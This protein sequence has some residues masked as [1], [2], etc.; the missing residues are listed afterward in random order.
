MSDRI[1]LPALRNR[2]S[3]RYRV[4]PS[5]CCIQ[6][7]S[8]TQTI[9]WNCKDRRSAAR[10]VLPELWERDRPGHR[11]FEL[12]DE[13]ESKWWVSPRDD[14]SYHVVV[15]TLIDGEWKHPK[16]GRAAGCKGGGAD[17]QA[18]AEGRLMNAM[19]QIAEAHAS[20]LSLRASAGACSPAQGPLKFR[21]IRAAE[22]LDAVVLIAVC[23]IERIG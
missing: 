19:S 20:A 17:L 4:A 7:D 15:H 12:T 11:H 1:H 13:C 22:S 3:R 23:G 9:V 2:V 6:N 18:V 8:S 21:L 10:I 5:L 16:K 14:G